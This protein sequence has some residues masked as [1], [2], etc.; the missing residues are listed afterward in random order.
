MSDSIHSSTEYLNALRA[1][2]ALVAA[3]ALNQIA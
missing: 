3:L 1:A 2:T